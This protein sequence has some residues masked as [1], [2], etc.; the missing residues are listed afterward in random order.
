MQMTKK[1]V[2]GMS[3]V[4]VQ[5]RT[6]GPAIYLNSVRKMEIFVTCVSERWM[7]FMIMLS[8]IL[9]TLNPVRTYSY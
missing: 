6:K 1:T 7:E 3:Y 4:Q 2:S 9:L 8:F 5:N